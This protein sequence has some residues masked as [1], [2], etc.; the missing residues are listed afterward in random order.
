MATIDQLSSAD[1]LASND[2]L[3]VFQ[4]EN[5]DTRKVTVGVLAARLN[6]IIQGEPDETIYSLTMAGSSFTVAVLPAA[7]G[8]SVWAQLTLSGTAPNGTI[9]LPDIDSR[10]NGQEVLV[11]VTQPVTVLSVIGMGANVLGAPTS[12]AANGFFRLR[13]DLITNCWYRIG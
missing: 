10:A 12:L 2:L 8:G 11:T 4:A 1:T 6:E 7:A 13:Y 3:P 5:A 9:N